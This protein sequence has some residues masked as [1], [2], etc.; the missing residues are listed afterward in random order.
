MNTKSDK[1]LIERVS[2]AGSALVYIL[3]AIAL[4]AALTVSFMEPSS[5]QTSSQNTFKTTSALQGQIDIIR[6]A[7]QECVLLYPNGDSTINTAPA[8][9]DPNPYVRYPIN[10]DS[11]HYSSATPGRSGDRLVRNMR[12][13]GNPTTANPYDHALIFSGGTGKFLGPA[14]DLFDDWQIYNGEDGV[15]YWTKTDKTDAFVSAALEKLDEKF[16]ECEA[17]VIDTSDAPAGAKDLDSNSLLTCPAN[18]LC[19]R[20]WVIQNEATNVYNGDAA[21]DEAG[22]P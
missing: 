13:P 6:S 8:G 1:N 21:G 4:L 7:I 22:C 20:V 18:H 2:E 9:S 19:F 15:F 17:D 5:Q 10:P 16:S 11:T 12:C 14:P 3:I